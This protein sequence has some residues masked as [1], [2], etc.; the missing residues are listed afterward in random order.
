[1]ILLQQMFHV[2]H[3]FERYTKSKHM[4]D[5]DIMDLTW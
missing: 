2:V 4:T 3:L 5:E 1:M